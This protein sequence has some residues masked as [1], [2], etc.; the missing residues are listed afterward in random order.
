MGSPRTAQKQI[1]R[2][3][4]PTAGLKRAGSQNDTAFSAKTQGT[5]ESVERPTSLQGEVR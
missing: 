5:T 2:P 1:L 3:A 4:H